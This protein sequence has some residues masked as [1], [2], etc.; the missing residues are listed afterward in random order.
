MRERI[1]DEWEVEEF[2]DVTFYRLYR[3]GQV[4]VTADGNPFRYETR[5]HACDTARN[6]ERH[7]APT[8]AELR[9]MSDEELMSRADAIAQDTAKWSRFAFWKRK[10]AHA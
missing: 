3:N 4:I 6:W 2:R 10:R 8:F 5:E 7:R 9:G 1:D